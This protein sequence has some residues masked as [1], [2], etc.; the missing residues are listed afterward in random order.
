MG[1]DIASPAGPQHGEV[2]EPF[3]WAAGF[4]GDGRAQIVWLPLVDGAV[5]AFASTPQLPMGRRFVHQ[6][7]ATRP[8]IVRTDPASR[9]PALAW[10]GAFVDRQHADL[11]VYVSASD[12]WWLLRWNAAA[13]EPAF[14]GTRV[15]NTVG[16]GKAIS[17]GRPFWAGDFDGDGLDEVLFYFPNDGHWFLGDM[18][19]DQLTWTLLGTTP[20]STFGTSYRAWSGR[21]TQAQRTEVLIA[22][23]TGWWLV[24][25]LEGGHWTS[26]GVGTTGLGPMSDGRPVW[27]G[28]F[29]GD[30]VHEVLFFRLSDDNWF[31]GRFVPSTPESATCS[32][33]RRDVETAKT[34]IAQLQAD[35]TQASKDGDHDALKRIAKDLQHEQTVLTSKQQQMTQAGCAATAPPVFG[36]IVWHNVGNTVGFGHGAG[37]DNRPFWVGR[38]SQTTTDELLFYFRGDGHWY[39]GALSGSAIQWTPA[40][41]SSNVPGLTSLAINGTHLGND[42]LADDAG[43]AWAGDFD[44]DG[45]TELVYRLWRSET[46]FLLHFGRGALTGSLVVTP[47]VADRT[48]VVPEVVGHGLADAMSALAKSGLAGDA[49]ALDGSLSNQTVVSQDPV[50]GGRVASGSHVR[51]GCAG[52][53]VGVKTLHFFNCSKL[54]LHLWSSADGGQSWNDEDDVDPPASGGVSDCPGKDIDFDRKATVIVVAVD[55]QSFPDVAPNDPQFNAAGVAYLATFTGDPGGIEITAGKSS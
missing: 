41:Q 16:F 39:R 33:L 54:H 28:D 48:I 19:G 26:H 3:S 10:R 14:S 25:G 18:V 4:A 40:G 24:F 8:E 36:S 11:L 53:S 51:L 30:G 20:V 37:A 34:T 22:G 13:S 2:P 23:D 50:A 43:H 31:M 55:S 52:Q 1:I 47:P 27:I 6:L 38:F 9:R 5:F 35:Q 15:G 44:G 45:L 49:F 46:F 29:N 21:F 7:A 12:D 32:A 17:D 42:I